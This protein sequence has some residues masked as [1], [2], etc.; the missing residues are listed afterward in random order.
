M[1]LRGGQCVFSSLAA[2]KRVKLSEG[3]S[4]SDSGPILQHQKG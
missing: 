3:V 2:P 1:K 4:M